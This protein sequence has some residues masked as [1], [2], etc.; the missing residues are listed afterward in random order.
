M[1]KLFG[2]ILVVVSSAAFG[3]YLVSR[4]NERVVL[5]SDFVEM[6]TNFRFE[7]GYNLTPV[8]DLFENNNINSLT[9]FTAITAENLRLGLSLE[10]SLTKAADK[11]GCF[12]ALKRAEKDYILSLLSSL[13]A[14]DCE[15]ETV[16]LD[17]GIERTKEFLKQAVQKKEKDSK[18]YLTMSLY[19]GIA[20]AIILL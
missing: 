14:A 4:L 16:M 9:K 8:E 3:F 20:T 11:T 7:I 2:M 1:L 5:L 18:V 17:G 6:L 19:I 15:S 12:S 13:G 10:Q